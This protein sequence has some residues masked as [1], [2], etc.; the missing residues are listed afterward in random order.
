MTDRH[1]EMKWFLLLT[2]I[3]ALN[4]R[5]KEP[6]W[7]FE[8]KEDVYHIKDELM[9]Y[10][11]LNRPQELAVELFLVPYYLYSMTSK[12]KAGNLMRNDTEKK[13]FEYYLSQIAPGPNDIEIP[14]KATIEVRIT[15]ASQEFSFHQPLNWYKAIGGDPSKLKK[16]A[17]ISAGS[18]NHTLLEKTKCEIESLRSEL[19]IC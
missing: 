18:F 10:I 8:D 12:D 3:D 5:V 13:P 14:D 4:R 7:M 16:K 11:L 2:K 19:N 17:W 6:G 15:C 9:E 1:N